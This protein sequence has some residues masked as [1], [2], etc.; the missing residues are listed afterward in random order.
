MKSRGIA[1]RPGRNDPCPCSSGRKFKLCCGAPAGSPGPGSGAPHIDDA[2]SRF[3]IGP[4]TEAGRVREVAERFQ[5]IQFGPPADLFVETNA[6]GASRRTMPRRD[7]IAA[8][9]QREL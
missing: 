2:G 5:K 1:T 6:P 8:E 4:L 3:N 9:R 7:T